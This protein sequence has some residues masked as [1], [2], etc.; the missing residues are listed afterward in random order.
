MLKRKRKKKCKIHQAH[1]VVKLQKN[2]YL[3]D[4]K[5]TLSMEHDSKLIFI[6]KT[7][8]VTSTF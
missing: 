6:F 8:V 4:P 3:K 5:L 7:D 2:Y 1:A